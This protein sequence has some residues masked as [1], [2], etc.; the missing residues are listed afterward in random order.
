MR[1]IAKKSRSRPHRSIATALGVLA[2]GALMLTTASAAAQGPGYDQ[3]RLTTPGEESGAAAPDAQA[4]RR[5][6]AIRAAESAGAAGG[7]EPA[8]PSTGSVTAGERSQFAIAADAL[9]SPVGLALGFAVLTLFA[10]AARYRRRGS[11]RS[12]LMIGSVLGAVFVLGACGGGEE[13][14]PGSADATFFG[15]QPRATPNAEDFKRMADAR[16]GTYR[17]FINWSTV[18][19]TETSGYDWSELDDVFTR[20]AFYDIAPLPYIAGVPTW[21][22]GDT[23]DSPV[24]TR[25]IR[26]ELRAFVRASAERYGQGS[27]FWSQL[28]ASELGLKEKAPRV[29]EI[30]NEQNSAFF[31]RPRPSVSAYARLLRISADEI[32]RADPDAR[33][34]VGG[35]FGTPPEPSSI[36]AWT[37]LRRLLRDQSVRSLVDVV[38]AHPYAP[39]IDRVEFQLAEIREALDDSGARDLPIWVTELG[40]GSSPGGGLKKGPAG[41]AMALRDAFALLERERDRLRIEGAVWFTWRDVEGLPGRRTFNATSG[42]LTSAGEAKPSF[43][44]YV[45]ATGGS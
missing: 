5:A 39:D 9:L 27:E 34:M 37:F 12:G 45:E 28:A 1:Q 24:R 13:A 26:R 15:V 8:P 11:H 38:G 6:D 19:Q 4:R 18:E 35:M 7:G 2:A 40:W 31:W 30:W 25:R 43:E 32:H 10:A 44:S 23:H 41:Q 14:P 3:Y 42:L 21:L 22:T 20:L 29:W 36:D 33:I 17:V 16:V